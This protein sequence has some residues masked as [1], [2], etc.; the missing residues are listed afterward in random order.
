MSFLCDIDI[1]PRHLVREA[2]I[3]D[4]VRYRDLGAPAQGEC[5]DCDLQ[6]HRFRNHPRPEYVGRDIP[7][8]CPVNGDPDFQFD[9]YQFLPGGLGR[10]LVIQAGDI[11]QGLVEGHAHGKREIHPLGETII[12]PPHS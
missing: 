2:E 6:V 7:E 3:E 1:R 10:F 4:I 12:D 8:C 9:F 5:Q 11:V